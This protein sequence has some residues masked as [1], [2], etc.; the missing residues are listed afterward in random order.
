MRITGK[1]RVRALA[2]VELLYY[3]YL[4]RR[5]R[6]VEES[7]KTSTQNQ[8]RGALLAKEFAEISR[9]AA[10]TQKKLT[11]AFADQDMVL[12]ES[13]GEELVEQIQVENMY[14]RGQQQLILP[15]VIISHFR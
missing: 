4:E 10:I 2:S 5:G 1:E 3:R 15:F 12:V 13:Y 9:K 14:L 7:T 6:T 11:R 8:T